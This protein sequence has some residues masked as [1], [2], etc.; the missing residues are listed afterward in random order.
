MSHQMIRTPPPPLDLETFFPWLRERRR[1][2]VRLHPRRG[3]PA[4]DASKLGGD[5]LWPRSKSEPHCAKHDR[6]MVGVLQVRR[7]DVPELPWPD[8]AQ[9]F[10]LFWCPAD[11]G[12][13]PYA[14]SPIVAWH[15]ED[16]CADNAQPRA[17]WSDELRC[18]IPALCA[19]H[20][21]RVVEYP[22]I[23]ELRDQER[24]AIIHSDA[25]LRFLK[26][27]DPGYGAP[28]ALYEWGLSVA[29]GTKVSGYCRWVQNV[30][31]PTCE[32][33]ATMEHLVTVA[34]AEF[35]G[36]TWYRW[37]S[38][39]ERHVRSGELEAR[40][41]VQSAAGLMLG[42]MGYVYVFGCR[43]CDDHPPAAVFQCS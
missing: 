29:D 37:L 27:H 15:T 6:R 23:E 26:L 28:D 18:Y 24:D 12:E 40:R 33:G 8:R 10:Q 20:P 5:F 14:P 38:E 25:L 41:T 22:P 30:E 7:K 34:S 35:D 13:P 32:C 31:I 17:Q 43:N 4:L 42:D 3:L 1:T 21:E 36:G 39:Q 19:V 11:F 16:E 2:T 9:L